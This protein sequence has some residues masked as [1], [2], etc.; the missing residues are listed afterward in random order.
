MELDIYALS[1]IRH[2]KKIGDGWVAGS[3]LTYGLAEPINIRSSMLKL[4]LRSPHRPHI[5]HLNYLA[6]ILTEVVQ[7]ADI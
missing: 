4:S 5:P 3:F 6:T 2:L 7:S 1:K